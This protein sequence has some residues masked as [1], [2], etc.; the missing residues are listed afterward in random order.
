M[1]NGTPRDTYTYQ[2]KRGQKILYHGVTNDP[3]RREN[4]HRNNGKHFTHMVVS[5][6]RSRDR[7]F[8]DE[9]TAI[10]RY[11]SNHGGKRPRY[12]KI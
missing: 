8:D 12:N 4:E 1:A 7:A 11:Q 5:P 3:E 6:P 10:E 9:R 2:L